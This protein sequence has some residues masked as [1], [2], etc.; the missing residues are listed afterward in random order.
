MKTAI[1]VNTPAQWYFWKNIA[2]KI[3]DNG[4]EVVMLFRDYGETLEVAE[5]SKKYIF[6]RSNS[7]YRK[8]LSIP[9]D[10]W[11]AYR[12]LKNYDPDII[13]GFGIYDALTSFML[14]KTCISFADS[15]ISIS[16]SLYLQYMI[17]APFLNVI[18]TPE[19]FLDDL[20]KK[21]IRVASY[22]E[23]AYL[24][25]NYYSPK[26]DVLDLMGVSKGE[27]YVLLRFNAFDAAHDIG[28]SGF[29][30]EDKIRLVKELEK[31]AR[32]FISSEAKLP[33]G[34]EDY[35]LKVSKKR[36]HD[37]IYHAKLLIAD[38]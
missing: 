7:K 33:E 13:T 30:Y 24:H 9:L 36:I 12:F 17:Y 26:D 6:A 23:L 1:I 28:I 35:A 4:K 37:V 22:K 27:D 10:V 34:L 5:Y 18:I 11:R 20:G 31:H 19:S 25:P 14:R 2:K 8:I 32:V 3:Q 29:T 21:Q 38:T 15:G 16:K